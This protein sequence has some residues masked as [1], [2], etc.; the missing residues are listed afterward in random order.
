MHACIY[1]KWLQLEFR[2]KAEGLQVTLSPDSHGSPTSERPPMGPWYGLV[3]LFN[4][5]EVCALV[6]QL[7]VTGIFC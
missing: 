2:L 6:L 7:V 1:Q 3:P 4:G 5:S